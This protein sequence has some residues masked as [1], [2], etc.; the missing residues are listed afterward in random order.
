MTTAPDITATVTTFRRILV[1]VTDTREAAE[2]VRQASVLREPGGTLHL[3]AVVDMAKA[4]HA[5]YAARAV[6]DQLLSSTSTALERAAA[7]TD[8]TTHAIVRGRPVGHLLESARRRRATLL[9]LGT[10]GHRRTAGLLI[11]TVGTTL[12]REAPCSVLVA[13]RD[14]WPLGRP[15]RIV[16]GVDGSAPSARAL[17][18]ARALSERFGARL[19]LTVGLGGKLSDPTAVVTTYQDVAVD[20]RP[21]VEALVA[22]SESADLVVVGSRGLH[23]LQALG[24]VSER[25]AH[26]AHA[27]VLV[28]RSDSR[29]DASAP[30]G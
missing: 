7:A 4:T 11:G 19:A 25:V 16:V 15:E 3:L 24:S 5:G 29:L 30:S 20:E 2:A 8:A 27:S 13:R 23:G 22:A 1:G 21:P 26:R 10:H 18:V 12:L 6:A 14:S 17:A 9:A 28:V